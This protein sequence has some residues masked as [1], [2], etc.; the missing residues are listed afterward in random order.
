MKPRP[1]T[2]D[3]KTTTGKFLPIDAMQTYEVVEVKLHSF[4]TLPIGG[5]RR[6]SSPNHL[7]LQVPNEQE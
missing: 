4:L 6:V 7:S 3:I 5:E 1:I 2:Y